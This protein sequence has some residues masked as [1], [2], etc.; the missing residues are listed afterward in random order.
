MISVVVNFYNNRREAKNTLY[1][2][3]RLYQNG[4]DD[5]EY[6]VIV[7]DHGS[8]LPL[9]EAEVSALGKEFKYHYIKDAPV[10]PVKAVNAACKNALGDRLIVMIDGAHII[11]PNVFKFNSDAY[12]LLDSPF[13]AIPA[14]HLGP[15]IQNQSVLE[16]YNQVYE[17]ELLRSSK[18]KENGYKLFS[19]ADAF[20]D[21]GHGWFGNLLETSCFGMF[22]KDFLRLGGFN[23]KFSSPG[24]GLVGLDFFRT[25]LADEQLKYVMLLGEASFHQFHGGVA[26]NAPPQAHPWKKFHD[27]YYA[28]R[29]HNYEVMLKKPY[30]LGSLQIEAIPAMSASADLA[31]QFWLKNGNYVDRVNLSH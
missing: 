9:S 16:G 29:G 12:L 2:L 21:G 10:S 27:E 1:S 17:D 11:T 22:K 18:W 23:E 28:I 14:F 19:I 20:A 7:L 3:S 6:E 25:A 5:I 4:C 15:K 30:F 26:S 8:Q 24:G 31:A 13:V